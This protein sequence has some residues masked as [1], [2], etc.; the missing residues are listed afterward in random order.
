MILF[1]QEPFTREL[2]NK[3]IPNLPFNYRAIIW[4]KDTRIAFKKCFAL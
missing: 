2:I 3:A 4:L 1:A